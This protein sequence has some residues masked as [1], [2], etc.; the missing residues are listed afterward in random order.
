MCLEDSVVCLGDELKP[1]TKDDLVG[2]RLFVSANGKRGS[3]TR[4]HR[5]F[6]TV[7]P[8]WKAAISFVIVDEIITEDVFARVLRQAGQLIG[9]GSFRPRNK[10]IRGRFAVEEIEWRE[11]DEI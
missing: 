5:I 3:G 11:T 9:I 8:G 1:I 7:L 2:D 6:P 4:V 10:G